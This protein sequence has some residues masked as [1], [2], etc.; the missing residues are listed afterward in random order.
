[1]SEMSHYDEYDYLIIND[2][3]DQARDELAAIIRA[4]RLQ[5]APQAQRHAGLLASLLAAD[6]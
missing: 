5:L 2:V 3:F 6:A 4:R 1:V